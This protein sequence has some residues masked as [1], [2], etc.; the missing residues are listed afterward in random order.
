MANLGV[1][2]VISVD[3]A[4]PDV[5]AGA[6]MIYAAAALKRCDA[7]LAG[8]LLVVANADEERNMKGSEFLVTEY[9]LKADVALLGEPSGITG[10]EFE[11]LHLLSRG[12]SCFK[13]RVRGTQ[14]H[15]SL[16]DWLPSV[17]AS[18]ML[19]RVLA[20]MQDE[21]RL[22]FHAHPLCPAPTVNLGVKLEGGVSYGVFPGLAEFQSDVRTL[23]GMTQQQL[24]ADVERCLDVL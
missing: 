10:A 7:E 4:Q 21:L 18:L 8:D 19:A 16:S 1:N 2:T 5:A 14:M 20:R 6:A 24:R 22:T 12:I 23:P 3:G 13:I 9:G 15:S 17:N 11:F